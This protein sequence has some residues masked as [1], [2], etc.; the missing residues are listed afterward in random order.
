[1]YEDVVTHTYIQQKRIVNLNCTPQIGY[2]LGSA[3]F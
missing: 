1:M 3:V 2:N